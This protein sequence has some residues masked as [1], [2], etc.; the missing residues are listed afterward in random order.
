MFSISDSDRSGRQRPTLPRRGAAKD[1]TKKSA[2]IVEA[3]LPPSGFDYALGD[4]LEQI[5]SSW[6]LFNPDG[7]S[8]LPGGRPSFLLRFGNS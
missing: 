4:H 7:L 8:G 1:Q 5:E 2:H 6:D 3:A